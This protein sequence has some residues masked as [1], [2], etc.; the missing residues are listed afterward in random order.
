VARHAV[1]WLPEAGHPLWAAGCAW[2]GRDVAHGA[3]GP[4][5][6][7]R[8]EPWRYGFHATLKAPIRLRSGTSVAAF[9]A[10]A[11]E[12][13][14]RMAPFDLPLLAVGELD[15]FVA[16]L[17][18]APC[19]PMQAL[20]DRCVEALDGFRA[21]MPEAEFERRAQG[22]DA[23]RLSLL[24]RWGYPHVFHHWRLH[25]TL[26]DR[27][28]TAEERTAWRERAA[29]HFAAALAVAPRVASIAV[30]EEEAPGRPFRLL[31]R[32]AL[33]GAG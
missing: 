9:V 22:L 12:L 8:A 10:G 21:P 24:R 29:A 19:P 3:D 6:P 33:G 14:S 26:T 13:V 2:L 15:G 23:E 30:L 16:L 17:P 20:A 11:R 25:L 28:P 18:T 7:G 32:L 31:T 4:A 27:L 5:P 1:Y